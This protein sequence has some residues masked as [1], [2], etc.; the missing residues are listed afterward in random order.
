MKILLDMG[1]LFISIAW[2]GFFFLNNLNLEGGKHGP[3][4]GQ[5]GRTIKY[6][7]NHTQNYSLWTSRFW[8]FPLCNNH[9]K[10]FTFYAVTNWVLQSH[11]Y[12]LYCWLTLPA[13]SE[14]LTLGT[15]FIIYLLAIVPP[16]VF[17]SNHSYCVNSRSCFWIFTFFLY[18]TL[19][20]NPIDFSF[21]ESSVFPGHSLIENHVMQCLCDSKIL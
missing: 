4:K 3:I 12:G 11:T 21:I 7:Y 8:D 20:P 13:A 1:I 17:S 15:W 9:K 6:I 18:C 16:S 14:M 10:L 2:E 19:L 5:E